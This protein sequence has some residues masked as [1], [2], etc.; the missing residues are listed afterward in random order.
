MT[1]GMTA[2]CFQTYKT[3]DS[4]LHETYQQEDVSTRWSC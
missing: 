2:K 1:R 3:K 4:T